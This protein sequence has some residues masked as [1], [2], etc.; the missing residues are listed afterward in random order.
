MILLSS[1]VEGGPHLHSE[2]HHLRSQLLHHEPLYPAQRGCSTVCTRQSL[3]C[4]PGG[5]TALDNATFVT[6]VNCSMGGVAPQLRDK[7]GKVIA[8]PRRTGPHVGAARGDKGLGLPLDA[9]A[10]NLLNA[11]VGGAGGGFGLRHDRFRDSLLMEARRAKFSVDKEFE[12]GVDRGALSA[13]HAT[14]HSNYIG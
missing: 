7:V 4:L 5:D 1:G 13:A 9:L 14:T 8:V 3:T 11:D 6:M 2:L 10:T 12:V